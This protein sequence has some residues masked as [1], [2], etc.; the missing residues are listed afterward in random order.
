[1]GGGVIEESDLLCV[2]ERE[3]E[4]MQLV[5]LCMVACK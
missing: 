2:R 4:K 3:E 1:M 5:V